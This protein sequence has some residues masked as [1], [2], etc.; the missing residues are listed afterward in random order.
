[1]NFVFKLSRRLAINGMADNAPVPGARLRSC[2]M[3]LPSLI[4]L[5][6]ACAPGEVREGLGPEDPALSEVV[7][8]V[9]LRVERS[10]IY[11]DETIRIRGRGFTASGSE[12]DVAVDFEAPDG[13]TLISTTSSSEVLFSSSNGGGTKRVIGKGRNKNQPGSGDGTTTEPVDTVTVIVEPPESPITSVTVSPGSASVA[14]ANRYT[15][16]A[17]GRRED[18]SVASPTVV[19]SATGGTINS[20]GTFTA[21]STAGEFRVIARLDGGTVADTAT[22]TVTEPRD[23]TPDADDRILFDVRSSLQQATSRTAA[24]APFRATYNGMWYPSEAVHFVQNFNGRGTNAIRLDW[25][26]TS[27]C[28]DQA[29][30]VQAG[31]T[32]PYPKE[33]YVQWKLHM[34]RTAEGGGLGEVGRFQLTNSACSNAARKALLVPR[35]V[36]DGGNYGRMGYTWAGPAP[37]KP[38]LTQTTPDYAVY[39]SASDFDYQGAQGQDIIQTVYY[40]AASSETAYDGVIRL[41]ING[42]LILEAVGANIMHYGFHRFSLPTVMRAPSLDQSEYIWDIVAWEPK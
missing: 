24:E 27:T 37:V 16:A 11:T 18:G 25:T 2:L 13:G 34:G 7:A 23:P 41:W 6:S 36:P 21:G 12:V 30:Q 5:I 19:W 3:L 42:R 4:A 22:V 31:F 14:F 33:I 9:D 17:T 1:M 10:R 35:D 38:L 32:S 15:F 8:S 29:R 28:V 26:R 20:A 39:G 40:K